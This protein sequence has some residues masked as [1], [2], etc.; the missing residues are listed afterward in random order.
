MGNLCSRIILTHY[1][2]DNIDAFKFD[3]C[4]K[5]CRVLDVYDGDTI[6]VGIIF[7]RKPYRVKVRMYGY[8]S[9]EIRPKLNVENR[10]EIIKKA[11]QA[12]DIL[13]MLILNKIVIIRIEEGT[14]DKY[15]RLLGTI[16]IKRNNNCFSSFNLN[17]NHY[18]IE[19][20]YGY[21]YNGRTKKLIIL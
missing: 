20:R 21:K 3:N 13:R 5:Y 18:M 10:N 6:T 2:N 1:D 16:F 14:W 4:S 12:R 11:K 9:P 7:E 8:N 17:V 19:N 15:G